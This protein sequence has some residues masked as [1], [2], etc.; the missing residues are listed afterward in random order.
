MVVAF[1]VMFEWVGTVGY[2]GMV[3]LDKSLNNP[4]NRVVKLNDDRYRI[5]RK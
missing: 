5:E 3:R 1:D 4:R 2:S